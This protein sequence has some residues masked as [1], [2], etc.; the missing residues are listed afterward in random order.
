MDQ[1]CACG[2]GLLNVAPHSMP[3]IHRSEEYSNSPL[4]VGTLCVLAHLAGRR[5]RR[6]GPLA[7]GGRGRRLLYRHRRTSALS[8]SRRLAT[9]ISLETPASSA[10]LSS[11]SCTTHSPPTSSSST[12]GAGPKTSAAT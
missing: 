12:R 9:A 10:V 1:M 2:C 6:P 3:S 7:G 8:A 11:L 5:D 4:T